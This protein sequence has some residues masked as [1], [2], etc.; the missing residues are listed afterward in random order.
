MTALKSM[1]PETIALLAARHLARYRAMRDRALAQKERVGHTDGYR[2]D[3][4]A[5]LLEVWSLVEEAKG[6]IA[7]I[8]GPVRARCAAEVYDAADDEGLL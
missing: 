2:L 4:I 7:S 5:E 1:M 8:A 6:D 3:E